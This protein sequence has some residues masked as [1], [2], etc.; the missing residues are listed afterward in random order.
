MPEICPPDIN[1][2]RK[3]V[4]KLSGHMSNQRVKSFNLMEKAKPALVEWWSKWYNAALF[5]T[6][7]RASVPSSLPGPTTTAWDW[8]YRW[9]PN[10]TVSPPAQRVEGNRDGQKTKTDVRM[11]TIDSTATEDADHYMLRSLTPLSRP[12]SP[13]QPILTDNGAPFW[14]LLVHP[15]VMKCLK[16]DSTILQYVRN[17]AFM[18]S[19]P[20][21][22]QSRT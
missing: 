20:S 9:H 5:Q 14:L 1:Q 11:L 18:E 16:R 10:S 8:K 6:M 4:T 21:T 19:L 12:S 22:L 7:M 2:V 3:A 15:Q 13:Y 17:S